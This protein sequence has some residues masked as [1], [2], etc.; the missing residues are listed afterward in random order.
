MRKSGKAYHP[1]ESTSR[2]VLRLAPVF[3]LLSLVW[4]SP[5]VL[6]GQ[7]PSEVDILQPIT[8]SGADD[9]VLSVSLPSGVDPEDVYW[10]QNTDT[11]YGQ[12]QSGLGPG[13]YLVF[14]PGCSA[15][16]VTLNEPFTFFISAA[17]STLPSCDAP[18]SGEITVTPNFGQGDISYSWSHDA[19]ETGPVGSGVCEQVILVSAVDEN[20]CSDQDIIVVEI[21]PLEVLTF[22]TSPSCAGFSDGAASAVATGGLGGPYTFEWENASGEAVGTGPDLDGLAAGGYLVTA[23]DTGG[24]S[25]EQVVFLDAPPPVIVSTASSPIS[26]FGAGDGMASASFA[27]AV[28]FDW[29]GPAGFSASGPDVDTLVGLDPGVYTVVV[30]AADGCLGNGTVQVETPDVLEVEA[31]LDLPAC[32]GLSDGVVGAVPSGGTPDYATTWTLPDGSTATGDFLTGVPSG[33]YAFETTDANGCSAAGTAQLEDPEPV[34]VDLVAVDP[35][36]A[37]GPLSTEGS[38]T[39]APSGGLAPYQAAWLDLASGEIVAFGLSAAGLAEGQYGLGLSDALGCTLDTVIAL[40][41]PD[42]LLVDVVTTEPACAGETTGEV[43][44]EAS[45]GTPD[46]VYLWTGDVGPIFAA[47]VADLGAGTYALEVTDAA[48]CVSS[49]TV[50]L[51]APEP[52]TVEAAGTPVGCTGDDGVAVATP[53]GGQAPYDVT[54]FD[55]AGGFLFSGDSI[56]GLEPGTYVAGVQDANGC[57]ATD[58]VVVSSLPPLTLSADVVVS[59]CASG[60]A[61]LTASAEGGDAPL[62]LVLMESGAAIDPAT[63][64]AL[65]PGE[66]TLEV[67]DQRGCSEMTSFTVHPPLELALEAF[68]AGCGGEGS[69]SAVAG[70]GD[71]S[72]GVT[73]SS[74]ELGAPA[75][76]DAFTADWSGVMAGAYSVQVSDGTCL[77]EATIEM[78]GVD[79]FDWTIEVEPFACSEAPG[80]ISVVLQGGLEPIEVLAGALDGSTT[81]SGLSAEDLAPGDYSILIS[82]A[83]G[84]ERDTVLTVLALP[85]IELVATAED[86]SCTGAE[87]GAIAVTFDGGAEPLVLSIL[88]PDGAVDL[89]AVSIP[90]GLYL[91]GVVDDRGCSADTTVEVMDPLPVEVSMDSQPESCTGTADGALLATV[92]GGSGEIAFQWDNGPAGTEWTGLSAGSYSWS[93]EDSNGCAVSGTEVVESAGGLTASAEVFQADCEGGI[94]TGTV[95]ITVNGAAAEATVLLGGLPADAEEMDGSSGVWTWFN[96]T[97]GAYGWTAESGP[98]CAASGQIEVALP[99]PL[100]FGADIV[101]PAC[102]GQVGGITMNPS[103]GVPGYDLTWS[104]VT[105][106]GDTLGGMGPL[107]ALPSGTYAWTIEDEAACTLDTVIVIAPQSSGLGLDQSTTQPSCGGALAGSAE[108]NPFGGI[109]PYTVVVDGAADTTSLPFLIPGL[110]PLSLTDANGCLYLDTISIDA[111]SEFALMAAVDSASCANAEDGQIVLTTE[112]GTGNVDFT[113]SGPFGATATGDTIEGVAAGV[114]EVTALDAAGCPAV[115]LV[116]VG[117]PPPIQ[118]L[119]DSLVRPSCSGDSNGLLSVSAAGGTGSPA[120]FVFTWSS[121]GAVVGMGSTLPDLGEGEYAVEV[122]DASG[123]TG[124]IASIPLVAEGD[125]ALVVPPDTALCAGA[126]LVLEAEATGANEAS[127]TIQG[128]D[129]GSGLTAN[130]SAVGEG[131]VYWLFT[132][133]RLGCSRTDSVAVIGWEVPAPNAG[134]DVLIPSGATTPLGQSG[135]NETWTYAWFPQEDVASPDAPSTSTNALF[136]NTTFILEAISAEGC[137]GTDTVEVEVLQELGIPSGFTPNADGVNDVW[138]LTGLMQYPSAEI[139]VFNRWGKVLFTQAAG[140]DP[141]DGTLNGIPVPVGTYYYHIR[142][143]EPILQTEWTGPVTIM[144]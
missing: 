116:E 22:P 101:Q 99:A 74:I 69:I 6:R 93:A 102:E 55:G 9:G 30:T 126:P 32:P 91:V 43:L 13:S 103:G 138:N 82:D 117:A 35:L 21:P 123:C 29:T 77:A 140:D 58:D 44:A 113:F 98:E 1:E 94:T 65:S 19:A 119:L 105:D 72:A 7:C 90:P 129:S 112:N 110:Y 3:L 108:L 57:L 124:T 14:V 78:P 137:L 36:C 25:A 89:P 100:L 68:A 115:L 121:S 12:V 75:S 114:Y 92:T 132:A 131:L 142:V 48:G 42:P 95:V 136:S 76:S 109:P 130:V 49:E 10:I 66:Y 64:S 17:V 50:E 84:C 47:G 5:S 80:G 45:G 128:G 52:L 122:T 8:C 118:V 16:G 34:M 133:T 37:E 60:G 46:Y 61:T 51:S 134:A 97:Q 106:S 127:W 24:C 56:S 23:T 144:R 120:E 104:G 85:G 28:N 125:V 20:G 70:G 59:D 111:A 63:W 11:L 86:V 139:T 67:T 31:F 38:I 26:C 2:G 41:A 15:L 71:P 107:T 135:G 4:Q 39:A 88:G 96:L 81:W 83:A 18:C 87:D 141:W 143:N 62:D 73:F 27:E 54:W 33:V 40:E 79:L 53:A